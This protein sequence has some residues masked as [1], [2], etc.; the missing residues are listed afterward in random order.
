MPTGP[1]VVLLL[2]IVLAWAAI[3][4][5]YRDLLLRLW[6]EPV[7]RQPVLIVESDDW[8]PGPAG[9]A[10]ALERVCTVLA[11][12]VDHT[13]RRAVMTIGVVLAAPDNRAIRA[14]AFSNYTRRTL[15][16]PEFDYMRNALLAGRNRGVL[17]L[18]LH[19]LEHL[20]PPAFMQYAAESDGEVRRWIEAGDGTE[21]ETLPSHVQSRWADTTVLPSR[22]QPEPEITAAVA[23]EVALFRDCF[24]T[25]PTVVVP[26]TFVW[27]ASVEAQWASHGVAVLVTPGRRYTGRDAE[28]RPARV[29]RTVRNGDRA[30]GMICVVR[31]IYFEPSYGHTAQRAVDAVQAHARLGRPALLETHRFNFIG[32]PESVEHSLAELGAMLARARETLPGLRFASVEE[33]AQALRTRDPGWVLQT[34][35]AR[36]FVALRRLARV[37]RL[38]KL[39]LLTGLVVPVGLVHMA[40]RTLA[41]VME[42]SAVDTLL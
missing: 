40:A 22:A 21:T 17:A 13:G 27:T 25:P 29:D 3:I 28:G 11:A 34:W 16:D 1:I 4:V 18:Q 2:L 6:R 39:A 20:W 24:G 23:E 36:T 5:A 26:P 41:R 12:H 15:L 14:S 19:G 10:D 9:H 35:P 8:G 30:S 42:P 7:L 37:R 38:R 32:A 33:I 31:D